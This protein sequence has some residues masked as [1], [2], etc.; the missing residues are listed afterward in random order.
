MP[1][2][3]FFFKQMALERHNC[4]RLVISIIPFSRFFSSIPFDPPPLISPR[5]VAVTGLGM[6]TPLGCGVDVTW[7]LLVE[8]E[9]GIRTITIEDL[10]MNRFDRE[11]QLHTFDQLTSKVVGIVPADRTQLCN[12]LYSQVNHRNLVRLLGCGVELEEPLIV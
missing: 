11:T 8:G 1:I 2:F 7:K 6:V 12:S 4:N 3:K 5:R 10:K 9:C